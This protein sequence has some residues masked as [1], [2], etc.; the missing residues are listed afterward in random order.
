MTQLERLLAERTRARRQA[1]L[2]RARAA[3]DDLARLG[4]SA[5]LCGSLATGRF[6]LHSDVDILVTECPERLRYAIEG[7]VEDQL[8]DL[9]F[10]V[11]Y[12]DE[13]APDRAARLLAEARDARDLR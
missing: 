9:P 3:I 7:V 5:R 1:A 10:D 11:V 12:L 4:V 8:R 2:D 6:R 13:V